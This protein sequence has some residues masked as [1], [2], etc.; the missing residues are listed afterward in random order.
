MLSPHPVADEINRHPEV[1][2]LLVTRDNR[3]EVMEKAL[4][5]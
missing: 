3:T 2:T 1:Q 4:G 5:Q